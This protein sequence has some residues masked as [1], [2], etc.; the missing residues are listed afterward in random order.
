[1]T[2]FTGGGQVRRE[3]SR[4]LAQ[5]AAAGG[6]HVAEDAFRS[7]RALARADRDD[8]AIRALQPRG[9]GLRRDAVGRIKRR[10]SS[11]GWSSSTDDGTTP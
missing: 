6:S 9:Q 1:M 7:A 10:S 11:A 3:A 8:D 2:R 5:C 4:V